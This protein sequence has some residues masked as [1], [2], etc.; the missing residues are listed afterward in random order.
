MFYLD[1][2][3]FYCY[4]L[5]LSLPLHLVFHSPKHHTSAGIPANNTEHPL[6]TYELFKKN[7]LFQTTSGLLH[8]RA[9][10]RVRTV[11]SEP[12]KTDSFYHG[13]SNA[14]SNTFSRNH[15]RQAAPLIPSDFHCWR[16]L[17][18]SS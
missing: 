18:L 5:C 2:Y 10:L 13:S 4:L 16:W 1:L 8:K 3:A 15:D 11:T 12:V 7:L 14:I 6:F 17:F 9:F